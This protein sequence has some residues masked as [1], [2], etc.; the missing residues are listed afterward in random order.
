[1]SA[2]VIPV[3]ALLL[4]DRSPAKEGAVAKAQPRGMHEAARQIEGANDLRAQH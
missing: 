2:L 1:M 3:I 4:K